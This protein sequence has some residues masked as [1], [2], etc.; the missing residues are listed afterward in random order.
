MFKTCAISA[1]I[2]A[3]EAVNVEHCGRDHSL[4]H[5]HDHSHAHVGHDHSFGGYGHVDTVLDSYVAPAVSKVSHT[6]S[7]AAPARHMHKSHGVVR[8]AF[9]FDHKRAVV[10]RRPIVKKHTHVVRKPVAVVHKKVVPV[11][12]PVYTHSYSNNRGYGGLSDRYGGNGGYGVGRSYGG[13]GGKGAA[14]VYGALS[15]GYGKNNAW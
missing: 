1:L 3:T 10:H 12:A 13:F 6:H 9:P 2:A 8:K 15:K 14:K 11:K 7:Y 5:D 4:D